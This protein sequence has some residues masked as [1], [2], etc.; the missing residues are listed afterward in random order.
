[1]SS[2]KQN[3]LEL[4][5]SN[6][7]RS[8]YENKYNKQYVP[9][10]LKCIMMKYSDRIIGCRLLTMKQDL[11]FFI[12]LSQ[13]KLKRIRKLDLLFRASDHDYSAFKF[14]ELCDDQGATVT[15]IK[16]DHG[17]IFGGYTS[18]SWTG[19]RHWVNDKNAFLFLIKSDDELI[20][21][22]CPLLFDIKKNGSSSAGYYR[23]NTQNHAVYHQRA[24]GPVFG[25]GNDIY[26]SHNCHTVKSQAQYCSRKVSY[27]YGEFTKLNL[28][29]GS[30]NDLDLMFY[31]RDYEV[32]RVTSS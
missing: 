8:E 14:H 20:D 2:G 28:C 10:T 24:I 25:A 16:T 31:V 19:F 11:D 12:K 9:T 18:E 3:D 27:D 21:K 22:K 13:M 26:I 15:I 1:M 32:F 6:Y 30:Y 17:N 23:W 4:I 7:V 29:G 5:I